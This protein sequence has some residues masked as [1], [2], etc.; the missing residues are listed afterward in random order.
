MYTYILDESL[1]INLTNR[2][3]NSCSFCIRKKTDAMGVD[4]WLQKEPHA[5]D[6]IHEIPDPL[7]YKEIVFCG[8]G[9]P[10]IRLP[11][12]LQ[13]CKYLK[14]QH[15]K[16]RLNTNGHGSLIWGRDITPELEGHIDVVSISLNAKDA[17]QYTKLCQP[18][19]G[20]DAFMAVLDFARNC[21]KYVPEIWLSVVDVI[22]GYEME[23]CRDIAKE[24]DVN[25]RIRRY[26]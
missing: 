16:V 9:E 13:I 23:L 19:Y 22:S 26:F 1:Y 5:E 7:K 12:L 6:V 20:E 10:T 17:K 2:C 4:L 25:F 14:S 8:Y 11:Q 18:I 24:L 15:A 3:T 21:K